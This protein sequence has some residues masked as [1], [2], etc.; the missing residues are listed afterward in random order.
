MATSL[1]LAEM[2]VKRFAMLAGTTPRLSASPG[3]R[4]IR[5]CLEKELSPLSHQEFTIC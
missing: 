4:K 5:L 2:G 1:V 3:A